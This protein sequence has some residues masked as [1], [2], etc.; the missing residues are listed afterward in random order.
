LVTFFFKFKRKFLFINLPIKH[1]FEFIFFQN[2]HVLLLDDI[3]PSGLQ[4]IQQRRIG[5]EV[6]IGWN[7]D[8]HSERELL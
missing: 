7:G 5:K 8:G 3:K 6:T 4:V 2:F 1:L